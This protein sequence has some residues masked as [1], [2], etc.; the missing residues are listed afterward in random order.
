MFTRI[1]KWGNSLAVRLPRAFTRE[2]RLRK[3]AVVNMTVD[4]GK[5]L[6]EPGPKRKYSLKG[7]V[8]GITRE[9][10][11]HEVKTGRAVGMEAW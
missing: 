11:H 10:V 8:A 5:I 6:I 7:L 9:N 1:Q 2:V 4:E 3:G